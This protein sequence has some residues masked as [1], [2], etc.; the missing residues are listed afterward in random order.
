MGWKPSNATVGVQT[1]AAAMRYQRL[2][3]F[4]LANPCQEQKRP[5]QLALR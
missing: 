2:G 5:R 3:A 1:T 4:T